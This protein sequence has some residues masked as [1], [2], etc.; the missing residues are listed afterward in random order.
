MGD[1]TDLL[2]GLLS[3]AA[4]EAARV[5]SDADSTLS[6]IGFNALSAVC[7]QHSDLREAA[8]AVFKGN[9]HTMGLWFVFPSQ[10]LNGRMPAEACRDGDV[11][12]VVSALNWTRALRAM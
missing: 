11:R 1:M 10:A 4:L 9:N 12:D 7:A 6:R 5:R 8:E 2:S 3:G